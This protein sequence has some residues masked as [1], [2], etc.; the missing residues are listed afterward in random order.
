MVDFSLVQGVRKVVCLEGI[1]DASWVIGCCV[2]ERNR[3]IYV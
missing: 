1:S 3:I 2:G